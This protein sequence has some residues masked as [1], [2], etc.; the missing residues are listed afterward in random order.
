MSSVVP[1]EYVVDAEKSRIDLDRVHRWLS[2]ESYWAQGRTR[3]QVERSIANSV[4]LGAYHRGEQVGFA[5]IVTDHSTFGWLCDVFVEKTHRGRGV[6]KL[7]VRAAVAYADACGL[8][9]TVLATRDAQKLYA[10]SGG[11][12]VMERPQGWMV[13]RGAD[14]APPVAR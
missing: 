9:I 11:F 4:A 10:Q 6:G 8:R 1:S 5:R 7:L 14:G 2:V 12:H 13:R 3:E